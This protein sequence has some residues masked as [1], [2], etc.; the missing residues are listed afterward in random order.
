LCLVDNVNDGAVY[1]SVV[2]DDFARN[3]AYDDGNDG[4]GSDRVL[5]Q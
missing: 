2:D 5:P 4:A 1:Y 3:Y